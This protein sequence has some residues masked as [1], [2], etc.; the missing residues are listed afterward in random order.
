MEVGTG[1]GYQAAVLT[2]M[3]TDVY[4]IERQ[5]DLFKKTKDFL[6]ELG[7]Q[8]NFVYGD[9]YKGLPKFAPFDRVIVTCGA[10]FMPDDLVKQLGGNSIPAIGFAA[11]MERLMLA[12]NIDKED[13]PPH[14]DVFVIS[15]GQDA[16]SNALKISDKLRNKLGITVIMDFNRSSFKS[17]MRQA[18]KSNAKYVVILGEDEIK[19]KVGIIKTMSSGEQFEAPL[20]T[21]HKHFDIENTTNDR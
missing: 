12:L 17:Q 21:I 15:I 10:P 4:T 13:P 9:G 16:I 7:Y 18:N 14:I 5:R 19:R 2:L 1:S 11:G 6:P 20:D 3:H 8:C